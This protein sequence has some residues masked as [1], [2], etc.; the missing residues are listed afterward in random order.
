MS[1]AIELFPLKTYF[2]IQAKSQDLSQVMWQD[3]PRHVE[4]NTRQKLEHL[5]V[6]FGH[7]S[8]FRLKVDPW[9]S[10]AQSPV[11]ALSIQQIQPLVKYIRSSHSP[12]QVVIVRS[13]RI[14]SKQTS[15]SG[16]M[17]L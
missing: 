1:N 12:N 10:C 6:E 15:L 14:S 16:M 7:L 3:L 8:C 2:H 13:S 17:S 11:T 9:F 5:F 4:V